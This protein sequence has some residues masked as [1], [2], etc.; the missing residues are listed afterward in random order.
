[1]QYMASYGYCAAKDE[2]YYGLK[3][4]MMI[5]EKNLRVFK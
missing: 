5:N 3:A 2:H 4:H 1:M